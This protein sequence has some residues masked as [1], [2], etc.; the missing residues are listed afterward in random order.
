MWCK[1][2]TSSYYNPYILNLETGACLYIENGDTDIS[3]CITYKIYYELPDSR[4]R[5]TIKEESIPASRLEGYKY[6]SPLSDDIDRIYETIQKGENF[7]ILAA[8]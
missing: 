6:S 8:F 2:N 5:F 7:E 1:I 4:N 3:D